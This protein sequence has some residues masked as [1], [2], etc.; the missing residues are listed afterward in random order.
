MSVSATGGSLKVLN[1]ST[2]DLYRDCLRLVKHIAGNSKKAT[3]IRIILKKEF[4]KNAL[5]KDEDVIA[6]LKAHAVRGLSNYLMIE[7]SNKD[8]RFKEV[9]SIFNAKESESLK[10]HPLS[11]TNSHHDA[12]ESEADDTEI[13]RNKTI[14]D[15]IANLVK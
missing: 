1:R 5:V 6:T 4:M 2:R 13:K 15:D 3:Q 12:T 9:S 14:A 11:N 8:K 7:A 10:N